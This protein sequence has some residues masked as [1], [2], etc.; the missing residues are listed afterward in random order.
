MK[1]ENKNS[2]RTVFS[3]WSILII[4]FIFIVAS[5]ILITKVNRVQKFISENSN[6]INNARELKDFA[7]IGVNQLNEGTQID[8]ELLSNCIEMSKEHAELEV[9]KNIFKNVQ[10]SN[11]GSLSFIKKVVLQQELLAIEGLCNEV[12]IDNQNIV[13]Q[14]SKELSSYWFYTHGTLIIACLLMIILAVMALHILRTKRKLIE[15]KSKNKLIFN[16]SINTIWSSDLN[17]TITEFNPA[18]QQQFGYSVQEARILDYK[19]M[20]HSEGDV[21]KVARS[22]EKDGFFTGEIVNKRKDGSLFVSFLSANRIYDQEGM[23]YGTMGVSRDIS[24]EKAKE[25]E[26]QSIVNNAKDII[27]TVSP[28]GK[29]TFANNFGSSLLGYEYDELIGKYFTVLVHPEEV[30]RVRKFYLNQ[31]RRK[32]KRS[33]LEFKGITKDKRVVWLGQNVTS[34]FSPTNPDEII[35]LQGVVRDINKRKEAESKLQKSEESFRVIVNTINDLFYL[36]DFRT[37]RF[38]YISPNTEQVLGIPQEFFHSDKS[39]FGEFVHKDDLQSVKKNEAKLLRGESYNTEYRVITN[40]KT[41]WIHDRAFPIKNDQG[42]VISYSGV[43]RDITE[44]K[45][46]NLIIEQQN[47]E[48]SHSI[49]YAKKI[50]N[51]ILLT[52]EEIHSFY[53]ECFIFFNPRDALSGDFYVVD[54]F[55]T[56]QL[57]L[58]T[59]FVVADCTGHGVPG[60]MLSFLCNSLIREAFADVKVNSTADVL[61]F[62][63]RKLGELFRSSSQSHIHDGMDISICAMS[64]DKRTLYFSGANLP[65]SIIRDGNVLE[66]KGDRQHVGYS[67]KIDEFTTQVIDIKKDDM[68]FMYSDGYQDQFGGPFGKKYMKRKLRNLLIEIHDKPLEEQYDLIKLDFIQWKA[69]QNQVDD[70]CVMGIRV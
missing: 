33:Y 63:R 15:E 62:A 70:I 7:A 19:T 42:R 18:A 16:N 61:E 28:E 30:D 29:F 43:S 6:C 20:Y 52:T 3:I 36:F 64:E 31:Y 35:A 40:G 54:R 55:N 45:S 24:K 51:S 66:I 32:I 57:G 38:E 59:A 5:I 11:N 25:Q 48:I 4:S 2:I 58:L 21:N 27:Y 14:S 39:F 22:L 23:F 9:I 68:I 69:D 10:L 44:V 34:L 50:Q 65:I 8:K 26:F 56:D 60:G 1:I 41:R 12:I 37:D 17:G 13:N 49:S 47:K 46:A 53:P 67:A